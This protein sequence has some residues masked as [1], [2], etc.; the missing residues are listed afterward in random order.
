[1]SDRNEVQGA[2]L[3]RVLAAGAAAGLA[4]G[5]AEVVF[6]GGYSSVAGINPAEILRLITFTFFDS[7]VAF[8][9]EGL[10]AGLLIHFT[11][12]LFIGI[13]FSLFA[14]LALKGPFSQAKALAW[15]SVV[16]TAIWAFNFFVLL[17]VYNAPFVQFVGASP[18]FFSKLSFGVVMALCVRFACR[19]SERTAFIGDGAHSAGSAER[20]F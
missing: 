17:P 8:G 9:P 5:L 3:S 10:R 20:I 7:S 2:P 15:S 4:G 18:A 6:M 19:Q 13:S 16:L 12:S 1:M 11:L 14:R